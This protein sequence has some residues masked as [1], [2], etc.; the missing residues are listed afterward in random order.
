MNDLALLYFQ[1]ALP[2]QYSMNTLGL[3]IPH[4]LCY[5]LHEG[6]GFF[7]TVLSRNSTIPLSYGPRCIVAL[8]HVTAISEVGT[9]I[10][11]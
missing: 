2:T 9:C 3:L 11:V 7:R 8:Q 1:M 10:V 4:V 6:L 5:A